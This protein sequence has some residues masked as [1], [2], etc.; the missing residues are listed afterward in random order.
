M[1]HPTLRTLSGALVTTAL[2]AQT[3]ALIV[4]DFQMEYFDG[5]EPGKLR[6]P[7]GLAAMKQAKR[8]VAFADAH[9]MP[10]FHIQHIGPA[11]GPLFAEG[12][13]HAEIHPDITPAAHHQLVQKTTASSFVKTDLHQR[14]QAQDIQTLIVCGLMT[15]NCV[16]STARDARPHGYRTLIA[17]DA[18]ATRAIDL[19]DSSV[20]SHQDLHRGALAS[21]SDGFAEIMSTNQIVELKV[22]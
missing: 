18:C 1:A 9:R 16:S 22:Q 7:D 13:A 11:N 3:T 21:V 17:G 14:L 2:D 5:K 20:M 6:I 10:V 19:W 12:S 8:L 15:H 4:I